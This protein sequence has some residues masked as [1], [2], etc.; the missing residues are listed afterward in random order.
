[1]LRAI[2][3][4]LLLVTP[5]LAAAEERLL[6]V[7]TVEDPRFPPL[8]AVCDAA[9]FQPANVRLGASV[10]TVRPRGR[11]GLVVDDAVRQAGTATGCGRLTTTATF[12]PQPFLLR[13]ELADGVYT[14]IGTCSITSNTVPSPG[15]LLV[16]CGL[17]ISEAP[18]GVLGGSVTSA[19]LFNPHGLP[20]FD[21][22]S[23]WTL[24][25]QDTRTHGG[26]DDDDDDQHHGH[27][28]RP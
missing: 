10:W 12:T 9:P 16:T 3:A 25:I 19:S 26:D 18:Q 22:G 15:L 14:A 2:A 13:L 11:D 8:A 7:R 27:P 24:R 23:I 4:T 20:G 6:V 21:T 28:G 1:M 5:L 17:T